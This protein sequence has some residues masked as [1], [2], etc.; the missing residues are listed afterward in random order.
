MFN[1]PQNGGAIPALVVLAV[2]MLIGGIVSGVLLG[3]TELLNPSMHRAQADKIEAEAEA[4]RAETAA[5]AQKAAA[6]LKALLE[7]RTVLLAL[8]PAMV[9]AGVVVGSMAILML[10]AAVAY[11]II[12]KARAAT[13]GQGS[14]VSAP[15]YRKSGPASPPRQKQG[16]RSEPRRALALIERTRVRPNQAT[17]DGFLAYFYD[18]ILHP[19]RTRLFYNTGIVR[20]IEDVYLTLLTDV[21]IIVWA[22]GRRTSWILDRH[23]RCLD[24]VRR[25]MPR[26]AFYSLAGSW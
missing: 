18:Y 3:D 13:R 22:A 6:D 1:Y 23:I 7:R 25:R 10:T 19:H 11:F 16:R 15:V 9:M 20:E 2:L 12:A 8:L 24:D 26:R 17:Y 21:K 5:K 14:A 4:L